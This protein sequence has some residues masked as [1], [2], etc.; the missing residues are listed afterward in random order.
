V[1]RIREKQIAAFKEEILRSFVRDMAVLLRRERP[2]QVAHLDDE[3][4]ARSLRARLD[5]AIARGVTDRHDARRYLLASYAL[6][7]TDE[8]PDEEARAV[9]AR[10][11][12]PPEEKV[13]I[14]ERRAASIGREGDPRS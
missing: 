11:G 13:D 8:G 1:F 12:L 2:A 7:W 4:L 5:Q 9:L 14:I 3:A 10:E 6:G